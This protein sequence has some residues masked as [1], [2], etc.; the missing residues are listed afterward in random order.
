LNVP[1][2]TGSVVQQLSLPAGPH[3]FVPMVPPRQ[4]GGSAHVPF[5]QNGPA[6][7]V[8]RAHFFPITQRGVVA[9]LPPQS[10]SVSLPFCTLSVGEGAWHTL[11]V[12]TPLV[13][14]VAPTLQALPSAHFGAWPPP[15]STSVSLPFLMPSLDVCETQ[16]PSVQFA[17]VAASVSLP[18]I[19]A[20]IAPLSPPLGTAVALLPHPT[21]AVAAHTADK[22]KKEEPNRMLYIV[23]PSPRCRN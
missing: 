16:V 5:T 2:G 1:P 12:Q 19:S 18:G 7:S 17:G 11:P 20:G 10:T 6:Q 13:Q 22:T 14:S 21:K 9:P 8:G 3:V 15:Q 4:L 23:A